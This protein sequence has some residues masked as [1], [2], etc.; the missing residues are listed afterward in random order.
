MSDETELTEYT[1]EELVKQLQSGTHIGASIKESENGAIQII[2]TPST[3]SVVSSA[4]SWVGKRLPFPIDE[5]V[6]VPE[7]SV[8]N[9]Q[10][11]IESTSDDFQAELEQLDSDTVERGFETDTTPSDRFSLNPIDVETG[12][13]YQNI[14][15]VVEES[16]G[17]YVSLPGSFIESCG[18][19]NC[20]KIRVWDNGDKVLFAHP[21][22]DFDM[23]TIGKYSIGGGMGKIPDE[24]FTLDDEVIR[25]AHDGYIEVTSVSNTDDF[26]SK[27]GNE[28]EN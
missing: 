18:L 11:Y 6:D 13:R 26:F 25:T 1:D 20:K 2:L 15:S 3:R 14:V 24:V 17:K 21:S 27:I 22:L 8:K 28:L 4:L 12:G 9:P 7:R 16:G 5:W 10:Q 19:V 23:N